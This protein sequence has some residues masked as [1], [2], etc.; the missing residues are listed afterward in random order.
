M[1]IIILPDYILIIIQITHNRVNFGNIFYI[2]F[3]LLSFWP[4]RTEIPAFNSSSTCTVIPLV[5]ELLYSA[6][7]LVQTLALYKCSDCGPSM[8]WKQTLDFIKNR[9]RFWLP[10]AR[11]M[12]AGLLT[13]FVVGSF[14]PV[15][16]INNAICITSNLAFLIILNMHTSASMILY[17]C[18]ICMVGSHTANIIIAT[19]SLCNTI[20]LAAQSFV[21]NAW[22]IVALGLTVQIS[23]QTCIQI[24]FKLLQPANDIFLKAND[25]WTWK[26]FQSELIRWKTILWKLLLKLFEL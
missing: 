5:Q 13:P 18:G 26:Q 22:C 4:C 11:L 8:D 24:I 23:I 3:C 10:H 7:T 2:F 15:K 12:V 21:V 17:Y 16:V 25:E 9:I 14:C 1:E 6:V 19:I 20:K